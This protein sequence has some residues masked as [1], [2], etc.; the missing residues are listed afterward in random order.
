MASTKVRNIVSTDHNS[1]KF[2]NGQNG[3]H[4]LP[5]T[6]NEVNNVNSLLKEKKIKTNLFVGENGTE[7]QFRALD[8]KAV[9]LIHI[10]TH[11]DYKELKQRE[12]DDAMKH[13]FLIM[14]GANATEENND[15]LL[16]ADEISTLNLRG[17]RMV[18]LSACN[19]GQR[20]SW[21]G[22]SFRSSTRL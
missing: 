13:C 1:G 10:A 7:K 16:R 6:L 22:W 12:A 8:G 18:V 5:Y 21:C 15:G 2:R 19:T 20:Y 14:S 17:C 11:G 4:E 3:Y 9:S